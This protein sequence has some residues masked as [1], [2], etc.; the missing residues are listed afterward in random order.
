MQDYLKGLNDQQ[1]EAVLHTDGP[2]MFVAGAVIVK[3]N[4]LTT[5]IA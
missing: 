2:L 3:T 4:V 5:L 1:L